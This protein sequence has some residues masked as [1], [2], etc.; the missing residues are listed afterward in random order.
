MKLS[1]KYIEAIAKISNIKLTD[2]E[3]RIF[4]KDFNILI[5]LIDKIKEADTKGIKPTA[6]EQLLQVIHTEKQLP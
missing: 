2:M 1:I 5:S 4:V 3:K 6:I